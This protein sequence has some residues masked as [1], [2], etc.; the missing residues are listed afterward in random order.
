MLLYC[1]IRSKDK[2]QQHIRENIKK[3][4]GRKYQDTHFSNRKYQR[5]YQDTHFSNEMGVLITLLITQLITQRSA[6]YSQGQ[7]R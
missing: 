5:K 3:I 7:V 2:Y 4:S 6:T 1:C